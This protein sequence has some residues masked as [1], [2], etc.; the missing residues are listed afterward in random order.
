[1][2]REGGGLILS[3]L[4]FSSPLS[5]RPFAETLRDSVFFY[6]YRHPKKIAISWAKHKAR[7]KDLRPGFFR[8]FL[9]KDIIAKY[10]VEIGLDPSMSIDQ[11]EGVFRSH[12]YN[13]INLLSSLSIDCTVIDLEEM[14]LERQA[15]CFLEPLQLNS[16]A[17]LNHS[18]SFEKSNVDGSCDYTF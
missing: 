7:Q 16:K 18:V 6:L 8:V 12:F 2:W 13:T 5:L 9:D 15:L 14:S 4:P 3:D 1:M 11:Q 10:E 17:S